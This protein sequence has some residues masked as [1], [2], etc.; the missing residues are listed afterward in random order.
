MIILVVAAIAC[1]AM[2]LGPVT[3]VL[4][5]EIFPNRIRGVAMSVCTFALWTACCILTYTFPLLNRTL[6]SSGTFWVYAAICAAGFIF[7]MS[8][9]PETKGK[10]LETLEKELINNLNSNNK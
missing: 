5:S 3:W 2:S 9:L 4:L 6:G 10:P 1:Y 7:F 8:K